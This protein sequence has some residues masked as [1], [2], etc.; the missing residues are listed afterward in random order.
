M[1]SV[2][3]LIFRNS[4]CVFSAAA[5][6]VNCHI[7]ACHYFMQNKKYNLLYAKSNPTLIINGSIYKFLSC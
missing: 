7:L 1:N 2:P 5:K 4:K 6:N 3:K